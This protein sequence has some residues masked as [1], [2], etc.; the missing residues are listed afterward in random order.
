MTLQTLLSPNPVVVAELEGLKIVAGL[1][2]V[3]GDEGAGKTR[4]LRLLSE[5][6]AD[7]LWFDLRLTDHDA[8]TPLEFWRHLQSRC[9]RWNETLC[10][11]L[12]EALDLKAHLHKQLFMLS[13]GSR[14]KVGLLALMVSGVKFVCLDQPFSALDQASVNVLV[15]FLNDMRHDNS[16]AWLVAD[17]AADPRLDWANLIDL[18][19]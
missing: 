16:R 11:Q 10:L 5:L 1:N 6:E 3:V 4:L 13:T 18:V 2:A 15:D 12:C 9:P 8:Q 17:Y 14:R 19:N 7:A